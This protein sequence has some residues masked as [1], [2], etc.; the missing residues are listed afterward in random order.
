[1]EVLEV[2]EGRE[3]LKV[4]EVREDPEEQAVGE[5]QEV[6]E[7]KEVWKVQKGKY[8]EVLY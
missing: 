6:W 3:V 2:W 8:Q 7:I 5:V 4:W 1:M